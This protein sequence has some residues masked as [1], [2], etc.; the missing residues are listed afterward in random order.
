MQSTWNADPSARNFRPTMSATRPPI[1]ASTSSK[2]KP[3]AEALGAIAGLG[4]PSPR[5]CRECFDRE[6]HARQF[7]ARHD[8]RQRTEVFTG[9]GDRK[10]S[11]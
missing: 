3:G 7:A 4:E 6:H 8:A 9:L 10:N 1:P 11:A 5:R 2:I